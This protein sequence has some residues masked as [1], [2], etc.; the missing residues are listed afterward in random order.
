MYP[1]LGFFGVVFELFKL[2][3]FFVIFLSIMFV[4]EQ[5]ILIV[6]SFIDEYDSKI[7]ISDK[8]K[9]DEEK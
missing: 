4:F 3:S 8:K 9:E 2:V 1:I 7:G 6:R 5:L